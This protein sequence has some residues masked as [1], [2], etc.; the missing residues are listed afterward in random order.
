[1]LRRRGLRY[2]DGVVAELATLASSAT[3]KGRVTV[4]ENPDHSG[5]VPRPCDGYHAV[6]ISL[7][8]AI[9]HPS[10][11]GGATRLSMGKKGRGPARVTFPD[12]HA[13]PRSNNPR[14]VSA[15]NP[16][17]VSAL[18]AHFLRADPAAPVEPADQRPAA[19]GTRAVRNDNPPPARFPVARRPCPKTWRRID[20]GAGNAFY[21]TPFHVVPADRP[22]AL[23][24]VTGKRGLRSCKLHCP[25]RQQAQGR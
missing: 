3:H 7:D 22:D 11:S 23:P 14:R 4:I 24:R 18:P 20:S 1:V 25:P 2:W 19:W 12:R 5:A 10:R 9:A 13:V 15:L 16:R 6:R 8:D 21:L 17:R